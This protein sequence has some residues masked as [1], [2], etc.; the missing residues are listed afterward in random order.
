MNWELRTA[1]YHFKFTDVLSQV[2]LS[3]CG[4]TVLKDCGTASIVTQLMCWNAILEHSPHSCVWSTQEEE[5][6]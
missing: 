2:A 4:L 3:A 5:M 1:C 6:Y